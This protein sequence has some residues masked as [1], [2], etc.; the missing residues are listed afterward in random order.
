MDHTGLFT[1]AF[2]LSSLWRVEDVRLDPDQEEPHFDL[3]SGEKLLLSQVCWEADQPIN[4]RKSCSWQYL[5][6]FWYKVF[7]YAALPRVA[8]SGGKTMLVEVPLVNA[9]S[10]FTLQFEAPEEVRRSEV[11][12]EIYLKGI[13]W[14]PLKGVSH[15]N[16]N[17]IEIMYWLQPSGFKTARSWRMKERLQE[18]FQEVRAGND[19]AES[20]RQWIIWARLIQALSFQ[21]TGATIREH[22]N[23]VIN[24][25][26]HQ[27]SNGIAESINFNIQAAIARVRGFRIHDNIFTVIYFLIGKLTH[28]PRP[29]Y[30]YARGTGV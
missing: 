20:L 16:E 30:R 4:D 13:R 7:I 6:F 10:G 25:C 12:E 15:L 27:M 8:C 29:P 21:T 9:C 3:I 19:P 28:L 18:V 11:K 2:E 26:K 22:T 14:G 17:Q 23:R 1:A 24:S 5:H